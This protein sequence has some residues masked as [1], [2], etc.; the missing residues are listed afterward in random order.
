MIGALRK[1]IYQL[2]GYFYEPLLQINP[3]RIHPVLLAK[4]RNDTMGDKGKKDRD[5]R[6]K[7]KA[8]QQAVVAKKKQQ[9]NMKE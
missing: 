9:K 4:E 2:T 3:S 6:E 8:K 7:Q 5:K 1:Y